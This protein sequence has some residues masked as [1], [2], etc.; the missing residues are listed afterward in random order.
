M[1]VESS[2]LAHLWPRELAA[3]ICH[4]A[5]QRGSLPL[6][7]ALEHL[8][9]SLLTQGLNHWQAGL[10]WFLS[11]AL[12]FFLCVWKLLTG[13]SPLYMRSHR[14]PNLEHRSSSW[15]FWIPRG[16]SRA[17]RLPSESHFPTLAAW[18]GKRACD[19]RGGYHFCQW[20]HSYY[21]TC[22]FVYSNGWIEL[23][24]HQLIKIRRP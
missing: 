10:E 17:A 16:W 5:S 12:I 14:P 4:W 21:S 18:V 22:S 2:R 8:G 7:A 11:S 24:L 13:S 19:S 15:W 9:V 23:E 6:L 1:M 3:W 20:C